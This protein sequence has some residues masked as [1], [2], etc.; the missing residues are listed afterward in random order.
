M[1]NRELVF[2]VYLY[3]QCLY[4]F[5]FTMSVLRNPHTTHSHQINES[6]FKNDYKHC[7]LAGKADFIDPPFPAQIQHRENGLDMSSSI[8]VARTAYHHPGNNLKTMIDPQKEAR[9]SFKMG[10]NEKCGMNGETE[11]NKSFQPRTENIRM[12]PRI[13]I[14]EVKN[15]FMTS[16]VPNGD[17][18]KCNSKGTNY[19]EEHQ[20]QNVNSKQRAC[21]NH[22]TVASANDHIHANTNNKIRFQTST[23]NMYSPHP[24]IKP[25]GPNHAEAANLRGCTSVPTGDCKH[26]RNQKDWTILRDVFPRY[27]GENLRNPRV[28]DDRYTTSIKMGKTKDLKFMSEHAGRYNEIS[29]GYMYPLERTNIERNHS[30][31][32]EGDGLMHMSKSSNNCFYRNPNMKTRLI[33][34]RNK[35]RNQS[36][37]NF[38]NS[39]RHYESTTDASYT[40]HAPESHPE[41]HA[42]TKPHDKTVNN[43][44]PLRYREQY[45]TAEYSTSNNNSNKQL[46]T[47]TTSDFNDKK[48]YKKL[49]LNEVKLESLKRSHWDKNY[50]QNR[51]GEHMMITQC[52][53]QDDLYRPPG[54]DAYRKEKQLHDSGWLQRSNVP[55]G[56]LGKHIEGCHKGWYNGR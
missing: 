36:A 17:S 33:T 25:S 54:V 8:T 27:R 6:T 53:T 11:Q 28:P 41:I 20:W 39:G 3:S 15:K 18:K 56:T 35:N 23:Q 19:S 10:D 52:S 43:L 38:G 46:A 49:E 21:G 29:P 9:T 14:T 26:P 30:D 37:V 31:I 34:T 4:N 22:Y 55:I 16:D 1:S 42:K 2:L 12:N 44:V 50:L 7:G 24:N 51:K 13:D 45:S 40:A 47:I 5:I 48:C 32:P